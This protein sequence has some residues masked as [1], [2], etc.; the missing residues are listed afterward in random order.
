M[1]GAMTQEKIAFRKALLSRVCQPGPLSRKWSAMSASMR[2]VIFSLVGAFCLPRGRRCR[3]TI[4]GMTSV[5]GRRG[6][7]SSQW[8]GSSGSSAICRC[9]SASSSG[10]G[11]IVPGLSFGIISHLLRA[12][13]AQ[14]YDS[15]PEAPFGKDGSVETVSDVSGG[16]PSHLTIPITAVH[17]RG[18]PLKVR[19]D[20]EVGTPARNVGSV[21]S[22]VPLIFHSHSVRTL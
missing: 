15:C 2:K 3:S 20:R 17:T 8:A 21:L 13:L 7:E 10:V 12:R 16:R 6:N 11:Q 19:H 18:V 22:R 4:C 14:A 5:A 9:I 1:D